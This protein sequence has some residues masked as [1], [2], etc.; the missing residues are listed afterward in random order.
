VEGSGGFSSGGRQ[1]WLERQ[2]AKKG[3]GGRLLEHE[4]GN[5]G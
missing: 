5:R 1:A 4:E 2:E 3:K